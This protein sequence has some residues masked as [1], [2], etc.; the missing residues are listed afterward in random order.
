[1][2]CKDCFNRYT[3]KIRKKCS[4]C[5]I[6]D[7]AIK[8]SLELWESQIKTASLEKEVNKLIN[9]MLNWNKHNAK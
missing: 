1:M 5:K 2:A 7:L 3:G 6:S 9:K 8:K 4:W